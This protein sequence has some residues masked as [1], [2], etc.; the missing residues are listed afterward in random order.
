MFG[1]KLK[2]LNCSR[3]F[4]IE[5]LIELLYKTSSSQ[6]IS[7]FTSECNTCHGARVQLDAS[8]VN[9]IC[10]IQQ[11]I[12]SVLEDIAASL[13][14]NL[15]LEVV[16]VRL[17]QRYGYNWT[18][19]FDQSIGI[20][21]WYCFVYS[22]PFQK[23]FLKE[24]NVDLLIKFM[25]R[26]EDQTVLNQSFTLITSLTKL[27]PSHVLPHMIDICIM[28]G[29]STIKQVHFLIWNYAWIPIFIGIVQLIFMSS[30]LDL[31][32]ASFILPTG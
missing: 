26:V 5:V 18:N 6:W 30:K 4:L 2:K 12:L 23:T 25:R 21:V 27:V 9:L 24:I 31:I 20:F 19:F 16:L 8:P 28:A 1:L 22:I 10:H 13:L 11:A 7:G 29:E 3:P 15:L 17:I 14:S 32:Y